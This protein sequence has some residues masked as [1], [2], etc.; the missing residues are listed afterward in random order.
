MTYH[1]RLTQAR[2]NLG[3]TQEQV[4]TA[5]G[6]SRT[7]YVSMEGGA[8]PTPDRWRAVLAVLGLSEDDYLADMTTE[9]REKALNETR[10]GRR[11]PKPSEDLGP[12]GFLKD[13][14]AVANKRKLICKMPDD[15]MEPA[16]MKG[17]EVWA[18]TLEPARAGDIVAI[19]GAEVD[20]LV[21]RL[22][23]ID[24]A[25]NEAVVE[26]LKTRTMTRIG[27]GSPDDDT[28]TII[29]RVV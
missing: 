20:C 15:S 1:H 24:E 16:Y 14:T 25:R 22:V 27:L 10:R 3:L 13:P 9:Q 6:I 11:N 4:A 18:E 8:I 28:P 29:Y 23:R 19:R 2:N 17:D 21:R 7:Q 12:V 26:D 5:A